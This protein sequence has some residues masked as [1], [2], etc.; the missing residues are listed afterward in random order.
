[1]K[2]ALTY[3]AGI[4][5]AGALAT[6]AFFF[7]GYHDDPLKLPA[8]QT[9]LT[10]LAVIIAVVGL[11]LGLRARRA[12]TPAD[13]AFGYSRA[14]GAGTLIAGFAALFGAIFQ[15]C[16]ASFINPHYSE[17]LLEAQIIKME[18]QNVPA[19]HIEAAEKM[20]AFMMSPA[21]SAVMGL[22][23]GFIF[24]FVLALIVAAFVRRPAQEATPPPLA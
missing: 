17:V 13:E 7:A 23:M 2:T 19:A 4:A 3:A 15:F 10:V 22:F 9:P 12:E 24:T 8:T 6:M 11:V 5:L 16:Y 14:L 20:M 18:E 21:M 1:M